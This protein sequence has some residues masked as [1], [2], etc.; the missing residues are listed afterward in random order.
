MELYLLPTMDL[1]PKILSNSPN[2]ILPLSHKQILLYEMVPPG[3]AHYSY[4]V[5]SFELCAY[6]HQPMKPS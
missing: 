5:P 6:I 2:W 4:K 1:L 3:K